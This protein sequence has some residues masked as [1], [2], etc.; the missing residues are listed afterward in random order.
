[1]ARTI[2]RLT[3]RAVLAA[4]KPGLYPDGAGLYL[5]ITSPTARS[6]LFRYSMGGRER[7]MGLGSAIDIGLQAAREAASEARKLRSAGVDPIARRDAMRSAAIA[8]SARGLSF[9][10]C[11]EAYVVAHEAGWQNPKHRAQW[12]STLASYV[13]PIMGSLPVAAIDTGHVLACLE[14]IW[15]AKPETA[16]RVRGRIEAVLDWARVRGYRDGENPARWRGHLKHTLASP[17]KLKRV[18][19]HASLPW[20]ELPAFMERLR[21]ETGTAARALE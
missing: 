5:Q 12:R 6:W 21:A 20:K 18:K 17:A 7:Q 13:Y 16:G 14:P 2:K 10:A 15:H 1:M 19:H 8:E 4:R 3:A 9:Q 11:G